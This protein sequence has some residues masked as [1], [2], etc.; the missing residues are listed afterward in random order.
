MDETRRVTLAFGLLLVLFGAL[1]LVLQLVPG[2]EIWL[3]PEQWWPLLVVGVGVFLLLL[4][5]LLRV[6]ALTIPAC[7]V[8]GVGVL[9]L[10]QNATGNWDSWAY[11]WALIPGFVGVGVILMGLFGGKL[12]QSLG[13]GLWLM[14]ISAVLFTVFGALLGGS[15]LL[16]AYWPALL[17]VLGVLML[18]RGLLRLH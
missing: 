18:L 16:G 4:A 13:V 8:G 2:L 12:R 5:L 11:A 6:P 9:L 10:W 1:F 14:V 17:I 7:V 3:E 15:S